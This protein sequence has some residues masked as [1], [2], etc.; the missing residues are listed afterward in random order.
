MD[1][2]ALTDYEKELLETAGVRLAG[3]ERF[4]LLAKALIPPTQFVGLLAEAKGDA[5]EGRKA[6]KNPT[7]RLIWRIIAAISAPHQAG[8]LP[9]GD[10]DN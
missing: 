6:R 1:P 7:A 5:L 10:M 3:N 2:L 9:P 8:F 4:F